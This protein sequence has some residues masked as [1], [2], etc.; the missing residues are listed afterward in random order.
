MLRNR[1]AGSAAALISLAVAAAMSAGGSAALAASGPRHYGSGDIRPTY[2]LHRLGALRAGSAR[3]TS[4]VPTGL[5]PSAIAGVYGLTGLAPS[6]RAGAGELIAIVDAYNDPDAASDLSAFSAEY[7]IPALPACASLTQ[8][9]ACFAVEQPAGTAPNSGSWALEE[10]LDI[11]WAHAEAPAAKIVLVEASSASDSSLFAAVSYA[12]GI[13]AGVVSMSWGG[14]ELPGEASDDRAYFGHQ[15]TLY[16]A[17]AGDGGHGVLYPAASADVIAVGGTTL[18]GCAGTS[19][20]GFT[21]ETAWNDGGGGISRFEPTAGYQTGYAGAVYGAATISALTGGRRGVPDVSFDA[22]PSTGV[23]VYDSYRYD[24]QS[25]WWDVGGT[26]VGAPDWAGILAAG[27]AAHA[28][29][30]Q[31]LAAIYAGGYKTNL[32]DVT[33]GSNGRCGSDC[34]AGIGYDLVTGL[35]SPVDYP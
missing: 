18:N 1:Q 33:G 3:Y 34:T 21:G 2:L 23:S 25:G 5:P 32:R 28:T 10:S 29:S 31:G 6:S 8:A 19:C 9:S 26:S 24:G 7:G 12:S 35:G 20:T 22:N 16:V 15:G 27:Q 30:L 17:A 4:A 11:E 14:N 13:G